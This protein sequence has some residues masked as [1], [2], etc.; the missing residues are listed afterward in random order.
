MDN[1]F[2]YYYMSITV[3]FLNYHVEYC[4]TSHARVTHKWA[5]LHVQV[6]WT[7]VY[8]VNFNYFIHKCLALKNNSAI[9]S[10]LKLLQ[11]YLKHQ[12]ESWE[13]EANTSFIWLHP[14]ISVPPAASPC[15]YR[16]NSVPLGTLGFEYPGWKGLQTAHGGH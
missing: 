4:C 15:V 12:A 3:Y 2:Q 6:N 11:T 13:Q 1:L 14:G 16:Y 9:K 7:M 10:T 8:C 5:N